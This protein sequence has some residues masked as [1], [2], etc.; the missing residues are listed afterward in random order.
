LLDGQSLFAAIVVLLLATGTK[1]QF[2]DGLI[3]PETDVDPSLFAMITYP[4]G[5]G[6]LL[7]LMHNSWLK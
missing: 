2:P 5:L 7:A 6:V 4:S 1:D 3:T